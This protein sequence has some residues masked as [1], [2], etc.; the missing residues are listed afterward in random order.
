MAEITDEVQE[1]MLEEAYSV[2]P[3]YDIDYNDPR[4][5]KVDD[6]KAVALTE[7][8]Q[9]YGGMIAQSDS[10]YE[11][12]IE[13][14]QDWADEQSRLQQ[15]R[16]D[17]TIEQIEQQKDQAHK[18]Y[19]KE[20]SGAYVDWQKQSNKFGV[21]AERQ[22]SAGL[23]GTGYSESSQVSMYNTYQNRVATAKE[24]YNRAVLNYN[25][26]IT[27]ARMQNDEALA[28]IAYEALEKQLSLSLEGFQYKNSL[29]IE[30]ANR[31]FEIDN[32]Y[33]NRY[34]D[35]L[36]QIN[37]ENAM[38]EE[39]RQ[40]NDTKKWKTEQAQIE[41]DFTAGENEKQRTF[42][43]AQAE[44]ERKHDFDLVE[45]NT[46][47]EKEMADY[48]YN[49]AMKK[50]EQ[51]FA[52]EKSLASYKSSLSSSGGG[53]SS[54]GYRI[55]GGGGI[56]S[57]PIGGGE[58]YEVSTAYYQG[59]KNPDC[60]KYGTFA[61]GYQPKG[62]SGHG[63]VYKTGDTIVIETQVM[64]GP[65]KGKKQK[66]EQNIWRADDGTIWIWEGRANEYIRPKGLASHWGST[67]GKGYRNTNR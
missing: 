47:A 1:K 65:D 4:F 22:A 18:D 40:Y 13:A 23:T 2:T 36:D 14:S 55:S 28:Q 16:T 7:N 44:I 53:G 50:L 5:G 52:N 32:V 27:E 24:S 34:Q 66:L 41:R 8:G 26:A 63:K 11:K 54:G 49:L 46:Q 43:A 15:E 62:I 59:Q 10:F 31:A 56:G 64:Y 67:D 9:L 39:I 42:E 3:N 33:Y 30:Q 6:D 12:Q 48:N 58:N 21:E 25:N 45:A 51:E 35:V 29:I 57:A 20:Q 38:A 19:L 60:A 17:F 61:N 37:H